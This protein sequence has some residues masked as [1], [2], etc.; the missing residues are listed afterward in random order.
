MQASIEERIAASLRKHPEYPNH[1][2]AKNLNNACSSA[3]VQKVRERV[4]G[5]EQPS[6]TRVEG[7]NLGSLRVAAQRPAE[8]AA[9]KIKRLPHDRGF[10]PHTLASEWGCSEE[11]VRKHAKDLKALKYVELRPGDWIQVVMNPETAKKYAS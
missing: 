2:I 4:F 9:L 7:I 10:E 1:R 5:S 6:E 3:D 8:T 11:T